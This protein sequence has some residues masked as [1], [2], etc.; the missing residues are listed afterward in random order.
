MTA[1]TA[2]EAKARET[3]EQIARPLNVLAPLIKQD[4]E[5]GRQAME[6]AGMPYFIAAGEKLIEAKASCG[7]GEFQHW[8]SRN[9]SVT[10]RQARTWMATARKSQNGSALPF[11][12]LREATKPEPKQFEFR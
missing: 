5:Q 6:K 3:G 1:T 10:D 9:F 4:I 11:S 2:I 7:H 8:V 12:S